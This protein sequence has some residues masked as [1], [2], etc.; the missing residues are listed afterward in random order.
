[1]DVSAKISQAIQKVAISKASKYLRASEGRL[2]LPAV[3][4]AGVL[5]AMLGSRQA[6]ALSSL[7][8]V[9][10]ISPD[11]GVGVT[12]D[13]T[14]GDEAG[15]NLDIYYPKALART[16]RKGAAIDERYPLVLFVH[17]GSWESGNKDQ[18]AFVGQSFAQAGYVTAVINYRKAPDYVYPAFV[19]DTAQAIA[20]TYNNAD[21][22]YANPKKMAVVGQSAGAF[23]A[24]AAVSNSDFLAPFD[25][26]PTDIKVVVG[27][28]GPYSYDFR[29]YD[30][31][32]A[33]PADGHPETIM[34]DNLIKG[35]Q[36][37]YLLLTAENDSI[38][39]DK[40]TEKMVSAL[41]AVNAEVTTGV[42][43]NASH[44]TSIGA[45]AAPLRGLNDV[46]QQVLSY[47]EKTLK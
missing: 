26:K 21:K 38:V 3:V 7:D 2:A 5:L 18:Y 9:N 42:I 15:Q 36:P 16:I 6:F 19:E 35:E 30:S 46:R 8:I 44:A 40:N 39:H 34:P 1:M 24:V 32:T 43:K 4:G 22:F 11:G 27:I 20:W 31:R 13:I 25:L 28:A 12:K 37:A 45:M 23:N 41:R 29:K 33:F 17:G 10:L 47:L 14:Y